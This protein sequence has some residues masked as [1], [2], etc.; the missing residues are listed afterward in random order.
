V[1]IGDVKRHEEGLCNL[2]LSE[3]WR[4]ECVGEKEKSNVK[5]GFVV[6]ARHREMLRYVIALHMHRASLLPDTEILFAQQHNKYCNKAL[7]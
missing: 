3:D 1:E 5:C 2:Y 7:Q 4:F 6:E